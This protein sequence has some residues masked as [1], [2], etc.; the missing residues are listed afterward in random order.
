M[1]KVSVIIPTYNRFRY[2][3]N[4]IESIKKQ[5]YDNIEIIVVNDG[6]TQKEYYSYDWRKLGVIFIH[7]DKNTRIKVGYVCCNYVLEKGI[8]ISEGD[9][10]AFCAD[11]DIWFPGKIEAQFRAMNE[12]GCKFSST[13]SLL[14]HGPYIEGKKYPKSNHEYHEQYIKDIF[15]E[16]DRIDLLINGRLPK[17]LTFDLVNIMNVINGTSVLMNKEFLIKNKVWNNIQT[18]FREDH[19]IWLE[20][21]KHSCCA[22]V[23]HPYVYYDMNHGDGINY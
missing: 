8:M 21:L 10:V 19:K 14:G 9:Y 5:T 6:S 22:Y 13:E 2:L 16:H 17:I 1:L 11:D 15:K 23:D 18:G 3:L 12:T 20:A 4:A 7:M